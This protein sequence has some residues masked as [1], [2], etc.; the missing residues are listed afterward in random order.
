MAN[1]FVLLTPI[2]RITFVIKIKAITDGKRAKAVNV[3]KALRLKG[4]EIKCLNSKIINKGRK[5]IAAKIF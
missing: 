2:S 4:T 1:I 3:E 5:Y